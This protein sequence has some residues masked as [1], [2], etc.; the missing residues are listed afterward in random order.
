MRIVHSED[1][2]TAL[3]QAHRNPWEELREEGTKDPIHHR[4]DYPRASLG[5][6]NAPVA[7]IK[8]VGMVP[9][10]SNDH[11]PHAL[12]YLIAQWVINPFGP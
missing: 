12:G 11:C 10:R 9:P 1:L 5:P 4:S 2:A 6:L 3:V 7:Y 8:D